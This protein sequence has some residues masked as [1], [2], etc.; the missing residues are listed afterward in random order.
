GSDFIEGRGGDDI[1]DGDAWLNVRI[2]VRANLDG[3]GPEI[4]AL[5][6]MVR[7]VPLMRDGPYN[8]GQLKI[9]REI[10]YAT[11]PNFDTAVFTGQPGDETIPPDDR[12][13][14]DPNDD[15]I[16]VVDGVAN[17]DGSDRLT[18]IERLQFADQALVLGGLDAVP[19]GV[20]VITEGAD[21]KVTVSIAGVTDADNIGPN[22]ATGAITGPVAYLWQEE[23]QPGSG[24][25]TDITFV[26]GGEFARQEGVTFTP[27]AAEA[28]LRLRVR[29]V[30]QDARGVLEEVFSDP[31]DPVVVGNRAPV[32]TP[33]ISDTTPTEGI[34]LTASP[35][36]IT[37]ADGLTTATFAFQWQ[38]SADGV[39]W[40]DIAGGTAAS[41]TP[42]QAQGLQ[43]L[44]VV[45][46]ST[47]DLGPTET[48]PSAATGNVGDPLVGTAAAE[49][50]NGTAFDDWIQD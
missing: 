26:A 10:L 38:Q 25:F 35:A 50:I 6:S 36:G 29:A 24:I 1:I 45:V 27:G 5:D 9:V 23:L 41:F 22:N 20:L 19:D 13:T 11:G 7:M 16:T 14:P 32:G 28:G 40:T 42:A 46:A 47:D 21:R 4:A 43:L 49:T 17:R 8:P 15:I 3:T 33:P 31:T 2:S 48:V 39:T 12:G 18:H 44:R 34:A 37:D 30:Y